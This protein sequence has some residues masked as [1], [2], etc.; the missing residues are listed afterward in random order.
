MAKM[1]VMVAMVTMAI[2]RMMFLMLH[3]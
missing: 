2:S 3:T 1:G